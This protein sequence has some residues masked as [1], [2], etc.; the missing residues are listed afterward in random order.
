[1]VGEHGHEVDLLVLGSVG[2]GGV[3]SHRGSHVVRKVG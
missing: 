3:G 1:L 2:R